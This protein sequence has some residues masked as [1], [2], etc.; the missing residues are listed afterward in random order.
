M[1]SS[2]IVRPAGDIPSIP[3]FRNLNM[4]QAARTALALAATLEIERQ[5]N[6]FAPSIRISLG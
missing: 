3:S 4:Y 2:R 6:Y 1:F 5:M